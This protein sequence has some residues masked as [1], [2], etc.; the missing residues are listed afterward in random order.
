MEML[1]ICVIFLGAAF[2]VAF[3]LNERRKEREKKTP[4]ELP[5]P[6]PQTPFVPQQ[7]KKALRGIL[8][9]VTIFFCLGA[10]FG[11][12]ISLVGGMEG[13]LT[14]APIVSLP[15]VS[16]L[17]LLFIFRKRRNTEV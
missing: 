11:I 8:V 12:S 2:F 4:Q 10:I 3:E 16:C 7:D 13:F 5:K 9:G 6:A 1:I 15:A 14:V 17:F